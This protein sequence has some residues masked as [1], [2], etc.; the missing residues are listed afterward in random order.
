ML[1]IVEGMVM[2]FALLIVCAALLLTFQKE[3]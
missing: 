1:L 2:C 3:N